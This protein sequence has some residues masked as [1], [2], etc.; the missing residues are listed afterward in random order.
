MWW[1]GNFAF[2]VGNIS[3]KS[4]NEQHVI[5]EGALVDLHDH[6]DKTALYKVASN[7]LM[8]ICKTLVEKNANF[9]QSE[10]KGQSP[11]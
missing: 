4:K 1:E 10:N 8:E 6:E 2:N 5:E 3:W 9:N 7:G 11:L